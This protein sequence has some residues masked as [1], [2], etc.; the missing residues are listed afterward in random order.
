MILPKKDNGKENVKNIKSGFN[1]KDIM[2]T[3]I[4]P[5]NNASVGHKI[6]TT[7]IKQQQKFQCRAQ[8][9]Y[10]AFTTIE[11]ISRENT[12]ICLSLIK[13]LTKDNLDEKSHV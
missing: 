5:T 8:E 10:N 13:K 6:A 11:V 3:A 7:T 4:T 2:N 12:S 9:F 1:V